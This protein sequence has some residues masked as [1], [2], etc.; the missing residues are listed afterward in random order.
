M[1]SEFCPASFGVLFCSMVL[2]F[3]LL[4]SVVS[5]ASFWTGGLFECDIVH[6]RSVAVLCMLYM[7]G[8]YLMPPL[9]GVLPVSCVPVRSTRGA[10]PVPCVPLRVTRGALCRDTL[11]IDSLSVC[12]ATLNKC[13]R[14]IGRWSHGLPHWKRTLLVLSLSFACK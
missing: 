14:V 8:G 2:G 9:Y 5:S 13:G 10:L 7:I 12:L 1:L 6:R 4:D 11:C 3:K